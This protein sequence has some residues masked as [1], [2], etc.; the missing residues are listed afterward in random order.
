MAD[1]DSGQRDGISGSEKRQS[2]GTQAERQ[3]SNCE[4]KCR[5]PV[6]GMEITQS[7]GRQK[8][9]A[10][11]EGRLFERGCSDDR[12]EHPDMPDKNGRSSS[13]QQPLH[14]FYPRGFER[15]S[16]AGPTNGFWRDADWLFCRDGFWRPVEPGTF[17]LAHGASQRMG[18]LRAYGNAIIEEQARAHIEAFL[19]IEHGFDLI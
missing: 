19:E 10:E 12:L 16:A 11:P 2:D 3:Q 17:P 5:Q 18:R 4:F 14:E 13:R 1:A 6:I 15:E 9:R 8:R 7:H